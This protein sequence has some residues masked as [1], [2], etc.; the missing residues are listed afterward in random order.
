M[1]HIPPFG[2][3]LC[4]L[5]SHFQH[6]PYLEPPTSHPKPGLDHRANSRETVRYSFSAK[7]PAM[8]ERRSPMSERTP[9][10]VAHLAALVLGQTQEHLPPLSSAMSPSRT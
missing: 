9:K 10:C 5:I 8:A 4:K 7:N 6:S 1:H 2:V 3:M